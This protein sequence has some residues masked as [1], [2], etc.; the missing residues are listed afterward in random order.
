MYLYQTHTKPN[1]IMGKEI[2]M[3]PKRG[4]FL[5]NLGIRSDLMALLL[6]FQ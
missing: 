1:R 6:E 5:K 3:V 2:L 4:G